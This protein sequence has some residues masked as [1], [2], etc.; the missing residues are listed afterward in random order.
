MQTR[1][2]SGAR[3]LM[4]MLYEVVVLSVLS[5]RKLYITGS[6][7]SNLKPAAL[8]CA[9][10]CQRSLTN[11]RAGLQARPCHSDHQVVMHITTHELRAP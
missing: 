11:L 2:G 5:D 9:A 6:L 7:R 8:L 4:V 10:G 3:Q 1:A